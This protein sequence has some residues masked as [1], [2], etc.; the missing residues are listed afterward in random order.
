MNLK[1]EKEHSVD[2]QTE[3]N[4]TP[5]YPPGALAAEGKTKRIHEAQ[6]GSDL[7][8]VISKDDMTA[9]DGAKHDTIADKGRLANGTTCN[10]FRLLKACGLPVAFE[11]QDSPTSFVAPKCQMLP[12][13]VVVRREAHGSYLKRNPHFSKGQL[14][15]QLVVEFFLKTKDRNWN[16]KTLICADPLML[17]SKGDSSV[18]L[19]NPAKPIHA[20]EPLLL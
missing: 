12:Y 17:F 4:P 2:A 1:Q 18:R 19:F 8:T 16:G 14:F 6:G 3:V 20:Q 13:E 9:G 7:V 5:K 11:Q 10:V 15:P